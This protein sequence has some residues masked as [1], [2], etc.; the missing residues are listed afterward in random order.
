M[1][2]Q[3]N[4]C[5]SLLVAQLPEVFSDLEP[6][7]QDDEN[8]VCCIDYKESFRT[9]HDYMR[10]VWKVNE[11]SDR[12][13]QL[14]VTCLQLNPANYTVWQ[15]R[16]QCLDEKYHCRLSDGEEK[17]SDAAADSSRTLTTMISDELLLAARLGGENPKNYQV[18]HHRRAMME[19]L[20]HQAECCDEI[21]MRFGPSELDYIYSVL[22]HD[23]KNYHAW[24]YRQWVV[25]TLIRLTNGNESATKSIISA[26]MVYGKSLIDTD[27]RNNSAWNYLWY[28]SHISTG[29]D[30]VMH[31][32]LAP[33]T[34][35]LELAEY[36]LAQ[37]MFDEF[38][39]SPW[40]FLVALIKEEASVSNVA[41]HSLAENMLQRLKALQQSDRYAQCN[42]LLSTLV[43][44]LELR[45]TPADLEQAMPLLEQLERQDLIRKKYWKLRQ[46][47]LKTKL[48][49][50]L[51]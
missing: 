46:E 21:S 39:E 24:S 4:I 17:S 6:V 49:A 47:Q 8:A 29:E 16:R 31:K 43:D 45:A 35:A 41:S 12:V 10:A 42:H 30:F 37:A 22:N 36:A 9:A 27:I 23:A 38:N 33:A 19:R 5:S 2:S 28:L 3:P 14:T 32:S 1:S 26:E 11:H 44:L 48:L 50:K 18:W 25:Q 13:L 51:L 15:Y 7:P 40:R 20:L 34:G